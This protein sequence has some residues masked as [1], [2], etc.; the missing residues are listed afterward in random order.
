M[1][2]SS[3]IQLCAHLQAIADPENR[4]TKLKDVGINVGGIAVID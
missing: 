3:E 1:S 4:Y 2:S